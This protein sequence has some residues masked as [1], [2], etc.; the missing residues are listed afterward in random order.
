M[1]ANA[2]KLD[3]DRADSPGGLYRT[4]LA[5][6]G[7]SLADAFRN[8]EHS[9]QVERVLRHS[10]RDLLSAR[11]ALTPEEGHGY[12]EL[13]SIRGALYIVLSNFSYKQ[14]RVECVPGDGLLQ[15]NFRVSGDMTYGVSDPRPLRFTRPSLHLWRQPPG[16]DMHEWTAPSAHERTVTVNLRPEFLIEHVLSSSADVPPLLE[17]FVREPRSTI[18]FWQGPLTAQMLDITTRLIDNPYSGALYVIYKEALA[19]ELLCATLDHLRRFSAEPTRQYSERELG[20]L[21]TARR[22]LMEQLDCPSSLRTL[23]RAVGLAERTL[24]QGFKGLYGETVFDFS[25]RCRMQH[26]LKLLQ[27]HW[28][29]DRV[30]EA[31]GYS[32]PTSFATA[33]RRHFGLRP[34]DLK[35]LKTRDSTRAAHIS[36]TLGKLQLTSW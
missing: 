36:A 6:A 32:H 20:S 23:A 14:A 1:N 28:S 35:R 8:L 31:T 7:A 26:A 10:K 3:S 18:D 22:L 9:P 30:A 29:V 13:T 27:E 25:L 4:A 12:W 19:L 16:I 2:R 33:F 34:I 11:V 21:S 17:R 24:T 5:G 15:F